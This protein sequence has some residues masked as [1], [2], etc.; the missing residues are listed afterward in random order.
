MEDKRTF[1]PFDGGGRW[2]KGNLHCHSTLSDG[3]LAVPELAAAYKA[4]GYDFI[5]LS[6]HLLFS[7][8]PE[9]PSSGFLLLPACEYNFAMDEDDYREFHFNLIKGT[10]SMRAASRGEPYAHMER[11]EAARMSGSD[12][13]AIQD[14]IDEAASRGCLVML[15]H[16][17]WS[18]DELDD[19]LRLE[20]VFAMEIYNH[21]SQYIEN[22]G[23][24]TVMWDSLLRRG[25][26]LW[27]TATDDNHNNYSLNGPYSD[28]FGGWVSVK[29]EDLSAESVASAL[30][31]GRF[32]SSTGP[33]ISAFEVDQG[34]VLFE[35]SPVERIYLVS[36]KRQ[37]Q[38]SICERGKERLT[39]F[40]GR[41]C[42]TE[43]YVR[44]ECVQ[45]DGRRAYTN[46]I[47]LD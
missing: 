43:K 18:L 16:P 25:V 23:I 5:A 33:E 34:K 4:R 21:S 31:E 44:M 7:D 39:Q 29:A 46:P 15:N 11:L 17:H 32:Y 37:Y 9:D 41:L 30:S 6:E 27:G 26:R 1:R 40:M 14:F 42:G 2:Y 35:C 24:S 36:D 19:V 3:R 13:P 10:E 38:Y 8:Y 45:A 28:S 22:M 12:Y 20:G 47:F